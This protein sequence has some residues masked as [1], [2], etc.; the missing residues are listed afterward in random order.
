MAVTQSGLQ[1]VDRW[2][3]AG[4]RHKVPTLGRYM[5]VRRGASRS[6]RFGDKR[7][8]PAARGN[9]GGQVASRH[10]PP[11]CERSTWGRIRLGA[12]TPASFVDSS[13]PVD[14]GGDVCQRRIRANY[15]PDVDD[16]LDGSNPSH[17]GEDLH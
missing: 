10:F 6:V 5:R 11:Q 9:S 12:A 1:S 17:L 14:P 16:H 4:C 2:R 13:S 3:L 7:V 8:A 15:L